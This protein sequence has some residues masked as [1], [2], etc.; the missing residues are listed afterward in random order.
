MSK[1]RDWAQFLDAVRYEMGFLPRSL[2]SR[3]AVTFGLLALAVGIPVYFYVS[4]V[5]LVQPI[6]Q[7]TSWGKAWQSAGARWLC[8]RRSSSTRRLRWTVPK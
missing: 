4:H 1:Q 6:P 7:P 2:R 8:W 3:I 5:Y